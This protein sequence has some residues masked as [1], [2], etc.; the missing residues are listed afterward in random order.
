MSD[1]DALYAVLQRRYD[2]VGW[3]HK[4]RIVDVPVHTHE[5]LNPFPHAHH[6]PYRLET[7]YGPIEIRPNPTLPD[8]MMVLVS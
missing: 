2:R 8:G 1:R 3:E 4:L 7:D 5:R 6:R